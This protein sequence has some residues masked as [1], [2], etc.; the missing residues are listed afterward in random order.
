MCVCGGGDDNYWIHPAVKKKKVLLKTRDEVWGEGGN[1]LLSVS[2]SRIKVRRKRRGI[3]FVHSICLSSRLSV[4]VCVRVRV[5]VCVCACACVCVCAC[6][7]ACV[8]VLCS[9]DTA[10]TYVRLTGGRSR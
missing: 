2:S 6:A 4:C 1:S 8:C 7:C 3:C 5:R 10:V 9:V